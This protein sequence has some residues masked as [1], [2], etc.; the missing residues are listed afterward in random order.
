MVDPVGEEDDLEDLVL[1]RRSKM[2]LK[3]A[4]MV[5]SDSTVRCSRSS[6]TRNALAWMVS[7]GLRAAR[8]RH[9]GAVGD[10]EVVEIPGAA[11]RV[12]H[13]VAFGSVPK[14]APPRMW[15]AIRDRR[16]RNRPLLDVVAGTGRLAARRSAGSRRSTARRSCPYSTVVRMPVLDDVGD[17]RPHLSRTSGAVRC[18]CLRGHL[19]GHEAD[20]QPAAE[21]LS[22]GSPTMPSPPLPVVVDEALPQRVEVG[23]AVGPRER[24]RQRLIGGVVVDRA[25]GPQAVARG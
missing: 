23:A 3:R 10:V 24:D 4:S 25:A 2:S 13:R 11:V 18:G 5:F 19:V 8:G 1:R 17:A 9:E 14:R 7:V 12:E 6:P 15:L 16:F 21:L 20:R 22:R